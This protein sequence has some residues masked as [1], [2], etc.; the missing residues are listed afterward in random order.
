MAL[1]WLKRLGVMVLLPIGFVLLYLFIAFICSHIVMSGKEDGEPEITIYI[2]TNGV[3]TDIVMPVHSEI[4]DWSKEVKYNNTVSEDSNY[5]YLAIGWGNKAFYLE[6]PEWKD[7]K[8]SV[9]FNAAFGLSPSAIHATYYKNITENNH[10]RK[11]VISKHQ[12]LLLVNYITNSFQKDA[13][14]HFKNIQ[15]RANYGMSDAFYEANGR[16]NLFKTCNTWANDCLKESGQKSCLWTIFD[17]G[18]FSVY[19]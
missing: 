4:T 17:T 12:Y 15:T 5:T 13:A 19:E 8:C 6:T 7:L 18:I 16:Y 3:H 11:I 9:A 2:K 1:K 10:C 14:G